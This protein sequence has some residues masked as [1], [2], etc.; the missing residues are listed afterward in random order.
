MPPSND[1]FRVLVFSKTAA[2]RH[3]CI[4]AGHAAFADLAAKSNGLF[5][6]VSTED[7]ETYFTPESLS[8]FATV[9]FFQNSR[10]VLTTVQMDALKGFIAQGGGYVGVHCASGAM[11][12]DPWYG[13]LVGAFFDF[14]PEPQRGL[15]KVENED[16][17]LSAPWVPASGQGL[18]AI[19][20]FDEWYNYKTNPRLSSAVSDEDGLAPLTVLLSVDH[21]SFEGSTMGA[22][23]PIAW[24]RNFGSARSFYTALGHFDEAYQEERFTEQLRRAILWTAKREE[25]GAICT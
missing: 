21:E 5:S 3:A 17:Y 11:Y 6:V 18:D 7:A 13:K 22:G 8:G 16:H 4:P 9:I 10:E 23:H 14:H 1:P 15:L 20:W 12:S 2:Y 24:C 19:P 25:D